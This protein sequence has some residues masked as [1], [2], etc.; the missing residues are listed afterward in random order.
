MTKNST[1]IQFKTE[2]LDKTGFKTY[3]MA[4]KAEYI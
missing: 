3:R 4:L 2:E 1:Q